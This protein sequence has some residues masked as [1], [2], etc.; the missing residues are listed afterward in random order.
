MVEESGLSPELSLRA[1]TL[2]A[3]RL[4]GREDL[5]SIESGKLADIIG[6]PANPLEDPRALTDVR[7]VMKNGEIAKQAA[8]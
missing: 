2:D 8:S 3:A 7:F 5:G 1:A 4:L 6:V